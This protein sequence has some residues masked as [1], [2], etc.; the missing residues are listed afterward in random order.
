MTKNGRVKKWRLHKYCV[1]N[2]SDL[3]YEWN[4]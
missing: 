3:Q 1:N 2:D 4:I